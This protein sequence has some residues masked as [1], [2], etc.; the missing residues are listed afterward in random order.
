M[1]KND[2]PFLSRHWLPVA[3][4][5]GMVSCD[6]SSTHVGMVTDVVTDYSGIV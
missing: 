6:I 4:H 2:S 3:L 5:L 1:E